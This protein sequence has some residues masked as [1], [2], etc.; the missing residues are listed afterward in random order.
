[1]P[2]KNFLSQLENLLGVDE[3][4]DTGAI[5]D[6][7][8]DDMLDLVDAVN[9]GDKDAANRIIADTNE[10]EE[11]KVEGDNLDRIFK[12]DDDED[13][14]EEEEIAYSDEDYLA[15]VGD[16]VAVKLGDKVVK[17]TVKYAFGPSDTVGVM[18]KGKLKMVKRDRVKALNENFGGVMG[19]TPMP[20]LSRMQKLAGVT[21]AEPEPEIAPV[22]MEIIEPM[23]KL[24]PAEIVDVLDQVEDCIGDLRVADMKPVRERLNRLIQKLNESR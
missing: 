15:S 5:D 9:K 21:I 17:G 3:K 1:M 16:Q 24:T 10:K 14:D 23:T 22:S 11:E 12:H 19:M 2:D 4:I 6:L 8:V 20:S 13:D 7:G 18:V